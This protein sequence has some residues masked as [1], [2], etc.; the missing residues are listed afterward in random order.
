MLLEVAP[1]YEKYQVK[2]IVKDNQKNKMLINSKLLEELIQIQI[3]YI[4][5]KVVNVRIKDVNVDLT[6]KNIESKSN[7]IK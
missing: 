5:S 4:K 1:K 6:F 3:L 7:V 2:A